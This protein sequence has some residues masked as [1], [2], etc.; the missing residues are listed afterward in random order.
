NVDPG[1]HRL[2]VRFLLLRRSKEMRISLKDGEERDFL[3][4]SNGIGWP[5][6]REASPEEAAEVR[7]SSIGEPPKPGN[8]A[9]PQ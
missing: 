3:C 9:S 6:L 1:E 2:H 8:R 4:S 5:T 7:A